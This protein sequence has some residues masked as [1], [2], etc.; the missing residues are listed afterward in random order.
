MDNKSNTGKSGNADLMEST[1][2]IMF[3][4]EIFMLVFCLGPKLFVKPSSKSNRHIIINA[5]SQ[6]VLAGPVNSDQKN[7]VLEVTDNKSEWSSTCTVVINTLVHVT[8]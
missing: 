3:M 4:W 6:C 1:L 8:Q 5:I 7:K 2:R